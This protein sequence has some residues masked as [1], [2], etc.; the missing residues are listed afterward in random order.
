M[1]RYYTSSVLVT[2]LMSSGCH[3]F[4]T[5]AFTKRTTVRQAKYRR[6]IADD[7]LMDDQTLLQTVE[8]TQ[9]QDLCK[10]CNLESGGSKV[11]MLKRLR[12]F[13]A[14]QAEVERQRR[15]ERVNRVEDG[16]DG[17]KQKYEVVSE[18]PDDDDD[19]LEDDGYFFFKL[20]ETIDD[21]GMA[22]LKARQDSNREGSGTK[23]PKPAYISQ[24]TITAPPIP[25]TEPNEHGERVVTVY[26]TKDQNDLTGVAA[27]QP[28]AAQYSN[29]VMMNGPGNA[30]QP[31]EVSNKSEISNND[32]ERAKEVVQELVHSLLAM[33][34][35]PA[36]QEEFSEGIQ[37]YSEKNQISR[38]ASPEGF[39]GFDPSKLQS[40]VL[41]SSSRAL[42][43]GRGKVLEDILREYELRAVGHDGMAGDNTE[44]GGGHYRE[45]NKVRAFLEGFRKAEVRR[46]AKETT[47]M[48]L[49][50]LASEG[51][52]GLDF[53]LASM[54][55]T[56]D[57]TGDAG[58]LNKALVEY[59]GDAIRQ[60][61]K[62]I[63]KVLHEDQTIVPE[64][65]NTS[66]LWNVLEEDGERYETLDP[67]DPEFQ[68]VMKVEVLKSQAGTMVNEIR[69]KTPPE[70][71]LFLLNLLRNR[72][73]AE[74]AFANDE[75]GRNLRILAYCLNFES[76]NDRKELL[77]KE[78]KNS[79]D[80]SIP[81]TLRDFSLFFD[82]S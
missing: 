71:L 68:R 43:A 48:L 4:T 64:I 5:P 56:S 24:S 28:N 82:I 14:R 72:I 75:K 41:V 67:S 23:L 69:S 65:D 57:D 19:G 51:V 2:L 1:N 61:E 22:K 16:D 26:N 53:M 77:M 8:E 40:D 38:S 34:G 6:V 52:Q 11:D 42:R 45:V 74:A 49:D 55:K 15:M 73:K 25:D 60:Q 54:S 13:A 58:E 36:F 20:P 33:T 3:G 12:D 10:Q 31:W 39:V 47:T 44:K 46:V 18:D 37:M 80:V 9:L 66:Q 30:P 81:N 70:Q 7:D 27:S 63:F 79:M 62:K 21:E 35:A 50:K 29:D 76:D 32:L 59:L 17:N 78:M